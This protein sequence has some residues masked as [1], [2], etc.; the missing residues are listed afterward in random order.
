LLME[1][2]YAL[3]IRSDEFFLANSFDRTIMIGR[4]FRRG[5]LPFCAGYVARRIRAK[6]RSC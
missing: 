3:A 1:G 6:A 2:T 4:P 5:T